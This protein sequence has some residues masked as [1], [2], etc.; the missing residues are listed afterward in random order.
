MDDIHRNFGK[1]KISVVPC[2][3]PSH[4]WSMCR[5]TFR[6]DELLTIKN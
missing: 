5:N 2:F 4:N 1:K 6:C 3:A